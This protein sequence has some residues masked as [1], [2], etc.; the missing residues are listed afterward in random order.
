M[1]SNLHEESNAGT[2]AM[3][4]GVELYITNLVCN[5]YWREGHDGVECFKVEEVSGSINIVCLDQPPLTS[6]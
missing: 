3:Q 5:L 2:L 1:Y 4:S 6:F